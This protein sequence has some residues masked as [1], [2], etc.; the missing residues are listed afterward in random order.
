[1]K[2]CPYRKDFFAKLRSDKDGGEPAT[3]EELDADLNGW[4]AAL[5]AIVKHMQDFYEK[6]GYNKGF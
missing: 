6:G 5:N 2:A 4:L 3:E 1:M